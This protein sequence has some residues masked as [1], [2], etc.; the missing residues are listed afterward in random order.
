MKDKA[1]INCG[2]IKSLSGFEDIKMYGKEYKRKVCIECMDAGYKYPDKKPSKR[3][4]YRQTA[5]NMLSY[6][7]H[8]IKFLGDSPGVTEQMLISFTSHW[9]EQLN[10]IHEYKNQG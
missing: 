2:E 1:C 10:E 6:L 4:L 9:R 5:E 3:L 8:Y 7:E